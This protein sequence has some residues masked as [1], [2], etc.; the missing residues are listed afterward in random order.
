[1]S[2]CLQ[3]VAGPGVSAEVKEAVVKVAA[4]RVFFEHFGTL[5]QEIVPDLSWALIDA[6]G[7]WSASPG[8]EAT[9]N[10]SW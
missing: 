4:G 6:N 3:S 9:G 5:A 7:S 1:M 8:E 10:R 2:G